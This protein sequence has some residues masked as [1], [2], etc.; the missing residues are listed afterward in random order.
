[1]ARHGPWVA[2][3]AMSVLGVHPVDTFEGVSDATD[4]SLVLGGPLYQLF[5]RAHLSGDT[6]EL[7]HRR[8]IGIVLVVWLPLLVLSFLA[9]PGAPVS[10]SF[11]RDLDTQVKFLV[12]LPVLISAELMVHL[13]TRSVARNFLSRHIIPPSDLPRLHDIVRAAKRIRN[14][15]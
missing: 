5:R 14:S 3:A 13:R 12:A 7:L 9:P 15:V 8:I 6:L 1:D 4:F 10:I 2:C 11:L